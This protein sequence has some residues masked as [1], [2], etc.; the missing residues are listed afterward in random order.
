MSMAMVARRGC[1]SPE[2]REERGMVSGSAMA[3]GGTAVGAGL[4]VAT[5]IDGDGG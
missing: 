1:Y 3:G 5:P 4:L 2:Q